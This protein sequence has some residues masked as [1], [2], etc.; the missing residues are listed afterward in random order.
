MV[1]CET[2]KNCTEKGIFYIV[3]IIAKRVIRTA[4]IHFL[5]LHVA[6][7]SFGM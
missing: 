5:I 1:F 7:H 6:F 4:E 2:V 3:V